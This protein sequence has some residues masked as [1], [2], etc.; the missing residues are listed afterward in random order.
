[1]KL[2]TRDLRYLRC[3]NGEFSAENRDL[4]FEHRELDHENTDLNISKP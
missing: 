2:G 1:M 3:G 4:R